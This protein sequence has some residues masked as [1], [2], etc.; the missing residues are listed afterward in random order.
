MLGNKLAEIIGATGIGKTRLSVE[1]AKS[2]GG[3]VVL[4]RKENMDD[5]SNI[6]VEDNPA[7]E[8]NG[9]LLY[10]SDESNI[11]VEDNPA[12]EFND[13]EAN[14]QNTGPN[15][16]CGYTAEMHNRLAL[17]GMSRWRESLK[18]P[19]RETV[20]LEGIEGH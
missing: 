5:E 20:A 1:V 13:V 11:S 18:G 7:E 4:S 16:M 12:E 3:E 2:I 17:L 10:T 9:C 19:D 15:G 6:S 8:F 14:S